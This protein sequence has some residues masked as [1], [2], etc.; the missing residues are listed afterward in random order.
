MDTNKMLEAD[1][2]DIIFDN[3][4]KKYGGYEL[5]KNYSKRVR[6][7]IGF[8]GLGLGALISF[9]FINTEKAKDAIVTIPT[10]TILTEVD[11]TKKI[12]PPPPK[13]ETLPPPAAA[14][15]KTLTPPVITDNDIKP[16]EHMT[17]AKDLVD[18]HVGLHNVDTGSNELGTDRP[19]TG[20]AKAVVINTPEKTTLPTFIDQMPE[21]AGNL[22]SY[23]SKNINYPPNAREANVEGRVAVQ[24]VV[25]ED[26]AISNVKVVRGIGNGCDEEAMRVI[27]AMPKWKP[28]KNNGIPTKVLF[29]QVIV[30]KLEK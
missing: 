9:S 22:M 12:L 5:R 27:R 8:L 30:F 15:T 29:T 28:G 1:Y 4:N 2:L 20:T 14:K 26:G 13:V 11:L 10:T 16:D 3:R 24:F 23:L 17:E 19:G 7:G 25:A 6:K 21:Y 18:A